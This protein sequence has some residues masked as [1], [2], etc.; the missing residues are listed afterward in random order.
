MDST[1]KVLKDHNVVCGY[2][3]MGSNLC[4]LLAAKKERFVVVD[5]DS[6]RLEDARARGWIVYLGDATDDQTLHNVGIERAKGLAAVLSSDAD[7][8]YIVLSS[9]L[10]N[11]ELKIVSPGHGREEHRQD[12]PRRCGPGHQHLRHRRQQDGPAPHQSAIW[13]DF[14]EISGQGGSGVRHRPDQ[15]LEAGGAVARRPWPKR[16]SAARASVSSRCARKPASSWY[17]PVGKTRLQE[18]DTVTAL[19]TAADVARFMSA[20]T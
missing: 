7:N 13:W 8:L 3:R 9:R 15:A 1:L 11:S 18:G 5:S 14:F 17:S 10:L 2:G 19:G 6:E 20:N 4:E 12:D 16:I